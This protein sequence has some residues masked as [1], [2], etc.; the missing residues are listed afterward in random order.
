[1]HTHTGHKITFCL[2]AAATTLH[3]TI[4]ICLLA[5]ASHAHVHAGHERVRL[6]HAM[7]RGHARVPTLLGAHAGGRVSA[8]V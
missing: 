1:M 2:T 7:E 4:R 5:A 8:A 6:A 3:H